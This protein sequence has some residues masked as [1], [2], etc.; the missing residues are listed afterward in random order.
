MHHTLREYARAKLSHIAPHL[1][2]TLSSRCVCECVLQISSSDMCFSTASDPRARK[3]AD[4]CRSMTDAHSQLSHVQAALSQ[5]LVD[6]DPPCRQRRNA[7]WHSPSGLLGSL[8]PSYRRGVNMSKSKK[9]QKVSTWRHWW[10]LF[11]PQTAL[12]PSKSEEVISMNP[13]ISGCAKPHPRDR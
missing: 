13:P 7:F 5:V 10:I 8:G 4:A 3:W 6:G 11:I 2:H 9:S 12:R 1:S